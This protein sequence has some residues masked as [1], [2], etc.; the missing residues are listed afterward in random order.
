MARKFASAS[1]QFANAASTISALAYPFTMACWARWV[2][3]G[4]V[5][6]MSITD[7]TP[8]GSYVALYP[9]SVMRADAFDGSTQAPADGTTT[10]ST[11]V[12]YHVA[13]VFVSSSSR[14]VYVNGVQEGNNT[15]VVSPTLTLPGVG[16][17]TRPTP[18]FVMNGD[19]AEAAIWNVQLTNSELIALAG[20]WSPPSVRPVSLSY[21]WPLNGNDSPELDRWKNKLD[22]N[23]QNTPTKSNSHPAM[24]YR[25]SQF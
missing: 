18:T 20:G 6:C 13:G 14:F 1:T 5:T 15:T 22:L 10:I 3:T 11:G 19:V 16:D 21:Y 25:T 9:I 8:T 12:W 23:L 2:T 24:R 7:G 4:T 17:I